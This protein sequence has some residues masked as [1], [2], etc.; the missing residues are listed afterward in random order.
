MT[1][2]FL[3]GSELLMPNIVCRVATPNSGPKISNL[4]NKAKV[5]T[6]QM[7]ALLVDMNVL[8]TRISFFLKLDK[9]G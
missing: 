8:S 7:S 4:P 1:E 9:N 3:G 6:K 5:K 2:L